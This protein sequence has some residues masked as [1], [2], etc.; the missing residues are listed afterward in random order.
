MFAYLAQLLESRTIW[1]LIV[2]L[3]ST[4]STLAFGQDAGL[5]PEQQNTLSGVLVTLGVTLAGIFR[6]KATKVIGQ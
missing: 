5:T 2:T 4:L 6:A 3:V 1:T